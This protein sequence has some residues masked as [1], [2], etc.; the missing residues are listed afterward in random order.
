MPCR[1]SIQ[2]D[3]GTKELLDRLKRERHART[4][5]ETI[6]LLAKEAMKLESSEIGTLTKLKSFRKDKHD[7]FD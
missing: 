4:Y 6:R 2:L 3:K 7:R 1:T 5:A